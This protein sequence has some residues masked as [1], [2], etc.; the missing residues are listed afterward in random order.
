ML[1]EIAS[2]EIAEG[3]KKM[4]DFKPKVFCL[5]TFSNISARISLKS[6]I[7]KQGWG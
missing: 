2:L 7:K 5:S 1:S 6:W 4:E 3:K